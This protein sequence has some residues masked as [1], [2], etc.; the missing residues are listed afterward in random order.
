MEGSDNEWARYVTNTPQ[1]T[2][3][4]VSSVY[5]TNA[6]VCS[7]VVDP[8]PFVVVVSRSEKNPGGK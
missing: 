3:G 5:V 4:S 6:P 2:T 8:M 1:M 7:C